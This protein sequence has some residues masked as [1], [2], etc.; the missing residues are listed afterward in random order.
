MLFVQM[1]RYEGLTNKAALTQYDR[2]LTCKRLYTCGAECSY[3][4]LRCIAAGRPRNKC[5]HWHW[6]RP[7]VSSSACGT[8]RHVATYGG[9]WRGRIDDCPS[10]PAAPPSF[11]ALSLSCV[12]FRESSFRLSSYLLPFEQ[13]NRRRLPTDA[14]FSSMCRQRALTNVDVATPKVGRPVFI[15][16]RACSGRAAHAAPSKP[17]RDLS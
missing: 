3:C 7:P 13:P 9:G 6:N 10:P 8:W 15:P 17:H 2:S 11:G 1:H 5:L 4:W 16:P 14:E 12:S